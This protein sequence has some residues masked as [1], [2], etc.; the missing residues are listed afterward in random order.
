MSE[1]ENKTEEKDIPKMS[2]REFWSKLWQLLSESHRL[3]F[4]ILAFTVV[5]AL[6]D[7]LKPYIVKLVIDNLT[8][9]Q[10][11]NLTLMF[12]L[13]GMFFVSDQVRSWV[14]YLNNI[15]ILR[16]SVDIEYNLGVKAQEKLMFLPLSY[17]E[18]ENTGNKI[19]KIERGVQRIMN[20]TENISW[21]VIPI[22]IQV[23]FSLVALFI[24]DYRL[25]M[26]LL[27]LA[28]IFLHLTF[29]ANKKMRPYRKEMYKK[30]EEA[31]GKMSQSIININAVQSFVQEKQELSNFEKIKKSIRENEH[32]QWSKVM[33][34]NMWRN[35]L[36]NFGTAIVL[37]IGIYLVYQNEI[38]I[39]SLIF[40]FTMSV[41]SY[42]SLFRLSRFYDRME[43]GKEGVS[44][45]M[46]LFSVQS[47]LIVKEN[48]L[49]P[50]DIRGEIEFKDVEFNYNNS[51]KSALDKINFKI[52]AGKMVALVGP[53]GSGKT[54]IARLIY[55]HYDPLSGEVLLDG[56]DLRDYSLHGFR[57]FFAI[58]PQEVEVFD[59]SVRENIAYAKPNA[60]QDEI[61]AVARTANAHEFITKLDK[62]YDTLVGERGIKLSGGQRQRLG[63]ARAL[64]A[65]PKVLIFDEATSNLDSQSEALI[66]EAMDRISKNRTTIIIAHRLSTI[67][68]ADHIFVLEDGKL[69]EEGNH[70]ELAHI[71]GGLYH[72]LLKLQELG[73]ITE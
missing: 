11:E 44:R 7:L 27:I 48:A 35:S 60:T 55:R 32:F 10:K 41:N 70:L 56:K 13:V 46:D 51:K 8:N 9:F 59:V 30:Y 50:D 57:R 53:S 15:K 64:L 25:G 21:E 68:K 63:I 28:P 20:L 58:V 42:S 39:G 69:V 54:T 31:S 17:H 5:A 40:A 36:V 29:K 38:T 3:I 62:G 16:L 33:L 19:V 18:T 37:L 24:T 6:L 65:D 2:S 12:V 1:T 72:K 67:K 71:K 66:K 61:E 49:E 52:K 23:S 22:L 4:V 73:E 14:T 26:S 34:S 45:L 47:N 43:E